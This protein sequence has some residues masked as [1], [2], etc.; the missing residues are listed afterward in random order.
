MPKKRLLLLLFIILSLSL[1]T[2]Q[3]NRKH[4]LPFRF[5]NIVLNGV[6]EVRIS[7]EDFVASPFRRMLLREEENTRLN[8]ELSRMI[9]ERQQWQEAIAENKRLK[10][11]LSLKEKERSYVT[12]ARVIARNMDQWSN[13]VV[14]DKGA[15][16]GIGKDMIAVTDSGLVGKISGI[17]TSYSYVL[18]L[19]DINF[20]AAAR[21]Q[22]SRIEGMISG[23]GFRRCELKYV[24]H[25]E[26]VKE[27]DVVITSGLDL[28]FPQG[29]PIGYVS[30][31]NQKD[32][33]MFQDIEV[34]PFAD[35][36]KI[37][38]VAII[39]RG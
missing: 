19:S 28:L 37:E 33:G 29:I 8:A 18:F 13:T 12:T 38:F 31:V 36:A 26:E 23:T 25:E 27:G 32:T 5:L 16:D 6:H 3:S 34:I 4:L 17:S 22:N 39:K 10:E 7:A 30:K 9:R 11:L 20:S 1:M 24:P 15:S 2:Y 21:L 14:L 35:D